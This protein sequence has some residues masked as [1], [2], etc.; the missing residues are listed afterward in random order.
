[1]AF[2]G[3]LLYLDD[4]PLS[5][6]YI[7]A[8]SYQY[9]A[10]ERVILDSYED[11]TGR[12]HITVAE[13]TRPNVRLTT[14]YLNSNQL[15]GLMSFLRSHYTDSRDRR[16]MVRLYDFETDD[17]ITAEMRLKDPQPTIARVLGTVIYYQPLTLEWEGL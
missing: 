11:V 13:H 15:S 7:Q 16:C 4:A 17:Y 1:M 6:E 3:H 14:K 5:Y 10:G 9:S 2:D 12:Q 8:N